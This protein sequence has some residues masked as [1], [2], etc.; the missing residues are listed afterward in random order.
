MGIRN[1]LS[2]KMGGDLEN[3]D[4]VVDQARSRE[5][6]EVKIKLPRFAFYSL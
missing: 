3:L 2:I 1:Q 4:L 5:T 6:S